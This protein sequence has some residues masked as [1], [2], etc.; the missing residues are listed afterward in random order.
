VTAAP[1][2]PAEDQAPASPSILRE[3]QPRPR[4]VFEVCPVDRP[5]RYVDDFGDPRFS[6]GYH[7]HEGIDIFAPYGT[8]IRAP[9]AG[10]AEA[11]TNWAGGVQVYVRGRR[12]FVFNSHLSEVGEMGR[13]E[14]GAIVG[15]VG[16][17]GNARGASPHD[18]FE[19]HPGGG[20]AVNPFRLLNQACRARAERPDPHRPTRA[21][22]LF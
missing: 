1:R 21:R 22:L 6:G 11:S 7:P 15:Y 12:G 9:F 10:K 20:P 5:R 3:E 16:N 17:S 19:W 4:P 13:V 2:I 18:H 14:A 8:P